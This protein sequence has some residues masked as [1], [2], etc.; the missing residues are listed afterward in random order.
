MFIA[1]MIRTSAALVEEEDDERAGV[2]ARR[3][4]GLLDALDDP[5]DIAA[6][7]GLVRRGELER[8]LPLTVAAPD[9]SRVLR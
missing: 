4:A 8:P 2:A 3:L 9:P 5:E 1:E 7:R 6:L